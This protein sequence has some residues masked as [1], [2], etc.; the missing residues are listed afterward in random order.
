MHLIF[1]NINFL[2]EFFKKNHHL[3]CL[4]EFVD[5]QLNYYNNCTNVLKDLSKEIGGSG[6]DK[7]SL[8]EGGAAS[9]PG[10]QNDALNSNPSMFSAIFGSNAIDNEEK[11]SLVDPKR[12]KVNYYFSLF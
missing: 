10:S 8:G 2:K 6:L 11:S 3:Q 1:W 7:K 9:G 4:T 5:A 12:A